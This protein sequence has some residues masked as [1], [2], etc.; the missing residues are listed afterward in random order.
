MAQIGTF[1]IE[2][3]SSWT[4]INQWIFGLRA[5]TCRGWHRQRLRA[6]RPETGRRGRSGATRRIQFQQ[7]FHERYERVEVWWI[8]PRKNDKIEAN[9]REF[10]EVWE[11][12]SLEILWCHEIFSHLVS[13]QL[14]GLWGWDF[15]A[16]PL[17]T[18]EQE[19]TPVI[20]RLHLGADV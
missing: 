20:W 1:F 10:Q 19:L 8:S 9:L 11:L 16:L 7:I 6:K 5:S 3:E 17:V 14:A 4:M 13:F 2:G 12:L 15:F 18:T